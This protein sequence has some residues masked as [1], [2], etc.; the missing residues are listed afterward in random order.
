MTSAAANLTV[1]GPPILTA[2]MAGAAVKL[3]GV[4]GAGDRV[5]LE[6]S[7]NLTAP[8]L[9]RALATNTVDVRA[10]HLHRS[11]RCWHATGIFS[12]YLPVNRLVL[13]LSLLLLLVRITRTSAQEENFAVTPRVLPRR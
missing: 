13:T 2:R 11:H 4:A 10:T 9:W 12:S 5:I 8:G 1:V 3:S 6:S 7:T